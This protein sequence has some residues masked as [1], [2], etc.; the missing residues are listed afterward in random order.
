MKDAIEIR[1]ARQHNLKNVTLDLPRRRLVVITGVSGS[2][3]SSLAFDTVFAEGQRRFVESLSAYA[4]QFLAQM[5][6][7]QVESIEGLSPSIAIDQRSASRNP[8]STVATVTEISDHLRLLF[9]HAGTPHCPDCG[10]VVAAQTVPEMVDTIL[11]EPEGRRLSLLAPVVSGRRGGLAAELK[12]LRR[13]GYVR[14]RL[15]GEVREL[16]E[17]IR[18]D[19]RRRHDLEVFVDRLVV[20]PKSRARLTDSLETALKLS[21]GVVR[22]LWGEGEEQLLSEQLACHD[23]GVSLPPLEPRS[24]SFNS[25][26][27]ACPTCAGLGYEMVFHPDLVIVDPDLPLAG[28]AVGP[29]SSKASV[30]RKALV[31][32][33]E[34]LGLDP[35]TPWSKLPEGVRAIVL[36][37]SDELDEPFEGVLS[38]LDRRLWEFQRRKRDQGRGEDEVFDR[39]DEEFARYM[40][41]RVCSSCGGARLCRESLAVQLGGRG[42]AQ[43]LEMTVSEARDFLAKLEL[44]AAT[45]EVVDRVVREIDGRLRFLEEVGLDYLTL[46]RSAATLAGGEAQRIRLATQ[47]GTSLVG[48]LYVLDEP[49]VGL[50][51]RDLARLLA[52]LERLRDQ[53]NSVLVVEHERDVMEAADWLVDMGPGA[54][55]RGGEV[56]AA[57][58]VEAI[59]AD[60]RSI[61]GAYL[62]GRLEVPLPKRRRELGVD[63]LVIRGAQVNNLREITVEIPLGLLVCVTGVSGAGKSSLVVDTLVPALRQR[64]TGGRSRAEAFAALDGVAH[65]DKLVAVDQEPIGRTPRSNPATY[66]GVLDTIRE[67]FAS[68]P[69]SRTRGWKASRFSFNVKGGRCEACKGDGTTRVE[70]H[71]LP[72]VYVVC[73]QCGGARYDRETLEVRFRGLNIAEVLALTVGEAAELLHNVPAARRKLETLQSVGLGY[74]ELGQSATT[75]SG[76]EAQRLKLSRELARRSTGR[77]LYVL[78][79]PTTGLHFED[80]RKLLEVLGRLVDQGNTVLVV[81][82]D[83]EVIKCADWVIDLGPEGG[84]EG[85]RVVAEGRPEKIASCEASFTGHSLRRLLRPRRGGVSC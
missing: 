3:K 53:G 45:V 29:W 51:Q 28:G 31:R 71:F 33:A 73:D 9:A 66:T 67:L 34:E 15:D 46:E 4:R 37:G 54:G 84:A 80:I 56:V 32:L 72:D 13:Q 35:S 26:A 60:D 63:A 55:A 49:S 23:C 83:L 22:V 40:E 42:I 81:E 79:E 24:F 82:H 18:V 12:R 64:L 16:E 76:G 14:I 39:V 77:T 43:V 10:R 47:I 75:L 21:G 48:V 27:G 62:S 52:T 59:R 8:R 5:P 11:S 1:G 38:W 70:M 65:L 57:G 68:L 6:K 30:G 44:D 78:D 19:G 7:P 61:T 25:P 74:L 85:G 20:R 69:E 2:G 41:R 58:T 17:E 50:H 36:E